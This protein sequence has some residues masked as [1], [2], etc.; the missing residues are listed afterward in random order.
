MSVLIESTCNQANQFGG[1][2]GLI[3]AES[4]MQKSAAMV[5][6]LATKYQKCISGPLPDRI[7][8]HVEVTRAD[9]EKLS[10]NKV[11]KS[12]ES[13]RARVQAA[14][15]IQQTR[16]TN[17]NS[18]TL[19]PGASAGVSNI[20]SNADK[21]IGEIRQFCQLQDEGR[22]LMRVATLCCAHGAVRESIA[23]IRMCLSSHPQIRAH[24]CRSSGE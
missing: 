19:A 10:G 11:S 12:S 20:I 13:I 22:S 23:V 15:N 5:K 2:T 18:Q 8:I 16:F 1:Y 3:P 24:D 21:L 4:A 7:D 6:D 17:P 9:Y 14:R